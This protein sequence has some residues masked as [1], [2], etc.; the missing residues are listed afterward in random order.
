MRLRIPHRTPAVV[1][2]LGV[3]AAGLTACGKDAAAP[4]PQLDGKSVVI[5][6]G[7]G[8]ARVDTTNLGVTATTD[9]ARYELSAPA[10]DSLGTAGP[11]RLTGS[12]ATWTYPDRALTVSATTEDGRLR[13]TVHSDRDGTL[14]WPL[15]GTDTATTAL[16][17]PRGEG[18]SLPVRD[19]FWNGP[20]TGLVGESLPLTSGL[21]MPFWGYSVGARG[22]GYIVPTDIGS[23]VTVKSADGRLVANAAHDFAARAGTG[24]YTVDFALTDASPVAAAKD[25]RAW[26]IRHGE[27]RSLRDKIA[28]NPRIARL[29]GAFHAYL[30]GDGRTPEAVE[31][32]KQLG[33]SKMWLGYDSGDDPMSAPAVTA[34]ENAGY[35]AGPYDSWANAQDPATA[36]NP[37]SRWP[38]TV[39]P[40]GCVHRTDGSAETGFGDRG[41]YLS[42]RAL[43]Q[44]PALYRDR[45]AAMTANGADSYFLDVDAA[46]EFFDDHSPAH[47]MTQ[48]Q[49]RDNRLDRMRWLAEDRKTVLGSEAAGS[50]AAP[51]LAF[52]HG[53]QTPISDRL[54]ALQRDRGTWGRWYPDSAPKFFFQPVEL[55]ADLVTAM[56]DPVY[57]VPLYETVLHDSLINA[58]RWELSYDKLPQQR[59]MRALTA[60][61][62]NTPLNFVLDRATLTEHG[63]EMARLQQYFAPLHERAA[64]LPMTDFR[65]LTDDHLVQRSVFGDGELNVTANFGTREHDGLP[66]GCVDAQLKGDKNPRRLCPAQ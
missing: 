7:T 64:T 41:C 11:V 62:N 28:T 17:I 23:S 27:F 32:M 30:W 33:L 61:L 60:I 52:D 13:V 19:R 56:F 48:R 39:W 34:A 24:D 22:I 31:Q 59:T 40:E 49:D 21:T 36:D 6:L 44:D 5:P 15:T 58:D 46:G 2:I 14:H 57:R 20:D 16:Q 37:S 51:V 45:Y 42:S 55:P 12:T 9:G 18:L 53:A 29:L 38:G 25:Y 8:T 35:L 65:W 63:A 1:A 10:A 26:V 3:A 66:G 4:A 43:E 50:W 47:P 54:W